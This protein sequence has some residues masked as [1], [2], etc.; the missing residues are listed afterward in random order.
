MVSSK[1]YEGGCSEVPARM[2]NRNIC[3]PHHK[4]RSPDVDRYVIWSSCLTSSTAP[5][6]SLHVLRPAT[7]SISL[8][9]LSSQLGWY[10]RHR[11]PFVN[12]P[13]HL[14]GH[15]DWKIPPYFLSS[16]LLA[17][18]VCQQHGHASASFVII[19]QRLVHHRRDRYI[20][21]HI[22]H[23]PNDEGSFCGVKFRFRQASAM[24]EE[25][26]IHAVVYCCM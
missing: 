13:C 16:L 6:Q 8:L 3:C 21:C 17:F 20:K 23:S 15:F 2:D 22:R 26:P 10:V 4:S 9:Y 14:S 18:L 25:L 12:I 24:A 19:S 1:Y 7:P 5:P 11:R